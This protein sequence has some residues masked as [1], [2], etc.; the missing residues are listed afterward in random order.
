MLLIYAHPLY[1]RRWKQEAEEARPKKKAKKGKAK[2]PEDKEPEPE[3]YTP[4]ARPNDN[5]QASPETPILF[6]DLDKMI[7]ERLAAALKAKNA[8]GRE[9]END[10][11]PE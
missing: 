2:Q 8:K 3:A 10:G 4:E 1:R 5:P 6:K 9:K 7:E 11:E